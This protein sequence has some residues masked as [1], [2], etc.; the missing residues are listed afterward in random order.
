MS[1]PTQ[2]IVYSNPA[3]A[4][5]WD[6]IMNR[7]GFMIILVVFCAGIFWAVSYDKLVNFLYLKCKMSHR[8]ANKYGAWI[9]FILTASILYGL[10]F[11]N[12]RY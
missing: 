10:H 3:Q 4:M 6:S 11:Y 9:A 5:F 12:T 8:R 1:E 2:I 7:G